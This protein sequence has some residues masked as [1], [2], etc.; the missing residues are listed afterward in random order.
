MQTSHG[1][2]VVC[3]LSLFWKKILAYE[4]SLLSVSPLLSTFERL[5][6]SL[7]SLLCTCTS[8]TWTHLSCLHH[9]SLQSVY[10]SICIPLITYRHRLG[11]HDSA[12]TNTRNS[13]RHVILSVLSS[14]SPQRQDS[15]LRTVAISGDKSQTGLDTKTYRLTDWPSVVKWLWLCLWLVW[16]RSLWICLFFMLPLL[17]DGLVTRSSDTEELLEAFSVRSLLYQRKVRYWF[18]PELFF[19]RNYNIECVCKHHHE[20]NALTQN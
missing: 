8:C 4:T 20:G 6:Q 15:N 14:E 11:K 2:L 13:S 12:A 18:F 9:K 5:T 16:K 3:L 1:S 10:A 19:P 17:G 7:G